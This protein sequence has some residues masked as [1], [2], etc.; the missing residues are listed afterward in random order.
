[1]KAGVWVRVFAAALV[2][3]A[4]AACKSGPVRRVSEPAARIQQLTVKADGSWSVDLRLENFSS[5]P[6]QFDRI[7]L[8][9]KLGDDAAGQLQAQPAI[10]IGPESADVVTLALKPAGAAKIAIADALAG[11]RSVN[12][13]LKG[14]LVATPSEAKQRTFQVERSSALSPAPGLPGVM[15]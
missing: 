7:D 10:S 8:Q 4:L 1:M 15:R 9:L 13:S 5:I 2:L 6:M 3:A 14:D 11:G 12:Y